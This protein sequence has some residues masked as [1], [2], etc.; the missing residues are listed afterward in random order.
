MVGRTVRKTIEKLLSKADIEIG[1][2]RSWDIHVHDERF[3]RKVLA[4]GSLGLGESYMAGWWDCSCLDEFFF[5][6]LYARLD[7]EVKSWKWILDAASARLFN[8]Q[9]PSRAFKVGRHHYDL[10]NELYQCML[11]ERMIY[12]CGYWEI[13]ASLNEAQ[14]AKLDLICRKLLLKPG[15]RLLDIGCGWGGTAKFAAERYGVEVVGVTVSMEQAR[16]ARDLCRGLPVEIRLEDYRAIDETFDRIVSVGMF[17]H[18]G[19]K[20]YRTYMRVVKNC[21]RQDGLFLLHT[22][23]GNRSV[24][25]T[26]PWIA[27]YIFPNSMIPSA[28]QISKAMEGFFVLEDW[29]NFGSDYDKTLLAWHRNFLNNRRIF[30]SRYD[31]RFCRMWSYYLLSSAG[32][33]RS[34]HKQVWHLLLS[35]KGLPEGYRALRY[36]QVSDHT[37][38]VVSCAVH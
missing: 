19:Y 26:D 27:R 15:M 17:E 20:N 32:A 4:N 34:R 6:V 25:K 37:A 31:E 13:A 24:T 10:S 22:I 28:K 2:S 36:Q 38:D 8:L 29:Q 30:Q 9:K 18:V 7:E 12:S 11:D 5:K 35:P 3:F 33:F 1:G 14:E 16:F 21:L 23:G